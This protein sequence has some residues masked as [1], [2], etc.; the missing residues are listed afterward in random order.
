MKNT[1]MLLFALGLLA[2]TDGDAQSR[3]EVWVWKD[4]TGVTHYSDVPVPGA[5]KIEIV[6]SQPVSAPAAAPPQASWSS[7]PPAPAAVRYTLLEF[8]S[9]D[10]GETFFGPDATVLVSVNLEPDLAGDDELK[11]FYDGTPVANGSSLSG[12]ERGE[13]TLTAV[14]VDRDNREKIRAERRF[15]VQQHVVANPKNKGPAVRPP[16]PTPK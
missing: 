11:I 10:A 4:D 15:S 2:A 1:W 3:R 6:G 14:V 9:P 13:H 16:P 12:M 5:K 8:R 7:P